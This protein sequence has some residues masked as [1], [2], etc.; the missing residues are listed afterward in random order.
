LAR[1]TGVHVVVGTG[2]YHQ[3]FHPPW[4][5]DMSERDICEWFVREITEGMEGTGVRAGIIGEIGTYQNHMTE[6][7][8]RVFRAAARAAKETGVAV[9]THTYLGHLALEQI[10]VLTGAGLAPERIVIGH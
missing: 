2:I 4:L 5:A 10:D 7:E 8:R 9:T 3:A 6:V 1:R